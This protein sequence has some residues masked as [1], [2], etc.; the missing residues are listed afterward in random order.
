MA[1]V[2]GG[3]D[4]FGD[5]EAHER[6]CVIE[7]NHEIDL[8]AAVEGMYENAFLQLTT[9]EFLQTAP[10]RVAYPPMPL[11]NIKEDQASFAVPFRRP[12]DC[13]RI[14]LKTQYPLPPAVA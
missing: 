3:I 13:Q 9:A 4:V 5:D 12:F 6:S 8:I 2:E 1:K 14:N 11:G 10:E 7:F